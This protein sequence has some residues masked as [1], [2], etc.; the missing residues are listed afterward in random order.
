MGPNKL[1]SIL[2]AEKWQHLYM[3]LKNRLIEAFI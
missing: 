2:W 1:S 3:E